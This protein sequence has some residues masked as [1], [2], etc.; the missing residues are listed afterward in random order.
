MNNSANLEKFF[1]FTIKLSERL[2]AEKEQFLK[3]Y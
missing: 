1:N 3:D 2:E